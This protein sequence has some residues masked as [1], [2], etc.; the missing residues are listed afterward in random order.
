MLA[1]ERKR[2]GVGHLIEHKNLIGNAFH[3][4]KLRA[5][6]MQSRVGQDRFRIGPVATIELQNILNHAIQPLYVG[7]NDIEQS[8]GLGLP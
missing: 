1:I 6:L 2:K 4:T 8:L 7:S 5:K 3:L